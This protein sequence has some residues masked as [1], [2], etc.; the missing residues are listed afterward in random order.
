MNDIRDIAE[1]HS[2][3]L[4][5]DLLPRLGRRFLR[6]VFYPSVVDSKRA[7]VIVQEELGKICSFIVFAYDSEAITKEVT[8]RRTVMAA[9]VFAAL[10][11]DILLLGELLSHARGFRTEL[12]SDIDASIYKIPELFVMATAPEYQSQGRGGKLL[13]RGIEILSKTHTK[14]LVKTSSR[15]AKE[16]YERH[17]FREIG[18][19][20]RGTRQV[21]LLLRS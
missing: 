15:Q 17:G 10:L 2:A 19:E 12:L 9:Y 6:N 7:L 16:F 20:Y 21:L 13:D 3:A 14:C 18:S 4:P 11:R 5:G 8:S 1:I